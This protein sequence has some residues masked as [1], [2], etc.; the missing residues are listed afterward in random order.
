M[1]CLYLAR[2]SPRRFRQ[3]TRAVHK[4]GVSLAWPKRDCFE[5]WGV[6]LIA[7]VIE[8]LPKS[9]VDFVCQT[10]CNIDI[11]SIGTADDG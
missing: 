11:T 3:A 5:N 8:P 7:R 10:M 2:P 1:A 9:R 6:L 4:T